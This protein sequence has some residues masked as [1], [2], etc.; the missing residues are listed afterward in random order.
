MRFYQPLQQLPNEVDAYLLLQIGRCYLQSSD[1]VKAGEL[2]K[3]AIEL[4]PSN[5]DARMELAKMYERIHQP[6]RAFNYVTEIIQLKNVVRHESNRQTLEIKPKSRGS[7]AKSSDQPAPIKA[8]KERTNRAP[9]PS[10][11]WVDR[12]DLIQTAEYLQTQYQHLNS[13]YDG[14]KA[15]NLEAALLWMN[16]AKALTDDFRSFKPFYPWDKFVKFVGYS[17]NAKLQA[18]TSLDSDLK[19]MAARLSKG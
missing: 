1:D 9:K 18:E 17:G 16:A 10:G 5:V 3:A 4:S 2:F 13:E 11:S 7:K 19:A 14:M 6:E 8:K 15:G 12:E